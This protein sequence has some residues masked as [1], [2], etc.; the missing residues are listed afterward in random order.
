MVPHKAAPEIGIQALS[1]LR[2]WSE[3]PWNAQT[4]MPDKVILKLASLA[5][6]KTTIHAEAINAPAK[7]IFPYGLWLAG[8]LGGASGWWAN[9][10]TKSSP[11]FL[12]KCS[13]QKTANTSPASTQSST[14]PG[15]M[16]TANAAPS[17]K[18]TASTTARSTRWI[19]MAPLL[20]IATEKPPERTITL[21]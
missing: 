1:L 10:Q 18:P 3:S 8:G 20:L 15:A 14:S 11:Q 2:G 16:H 5:L 7:V 13:R 4:P 6:D 17:K 21:V 12:T 19:F 9:H